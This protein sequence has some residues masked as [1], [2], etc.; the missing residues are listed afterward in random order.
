[1]ALNYNSRKFHNISQGLNVIALFTVVIYCHFMVK[2][3]FC[4]KKMFYHHPEMTVNCH[5]IV[6]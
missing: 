5:S 2:L 1:M 3:S 6:L 4:V